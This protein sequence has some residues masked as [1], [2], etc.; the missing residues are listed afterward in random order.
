MTSTPYYLRP[1]RQTEAQR[2]FKHGKVLPMKGRA[3]R[4]APL[5]RPSGRALLRGLAGFAASITNAGRGR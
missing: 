3:L 1:A 5:I 4:F 2:L